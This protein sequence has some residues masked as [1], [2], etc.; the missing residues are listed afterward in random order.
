MS[1]DVEP[2]LRPEQGQL[3]SF[4]RATNRTGLEELEKGSGRGRFPLRCLSQGAD[5]GVE[6][7]I[8][9]GEEKVLPAGEVGVEG[10]P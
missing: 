8:D 7:G 2:E 9:H 4:R 10:P 6:V 1:D 5:L 3:P